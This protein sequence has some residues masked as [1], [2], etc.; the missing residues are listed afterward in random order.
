MN[1]DLAVL[2]SFAESRESTFRK[3]L[4]PESSQRKPPFSIL[5]K[6]TR[7]KFECEGQRSS[8]PALTVSA[9]AS[10]TVDDPLGALADDGFSKHCAL[11]CPAP[12]SAVSAN[13]TAFAPDLAPVIKATRTKG[14]TSLREIAAELMARGIGT[15]WGEQWGVSNVK[16]LLLQLDAMK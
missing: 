8:Y 6:L 3:P 5:E 7:A 1:H 2:D 11:P 15:R 14:C 10:N 9:P 13:T 12:P 16:A 4:W